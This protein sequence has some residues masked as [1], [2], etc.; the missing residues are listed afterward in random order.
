[1]LIYKEDASMLDRTRQFVHPTRVWI[2]QGP[3]LRKALLLLLLLNWVC[4][5]F[6]ACA[7]AAQGSSVGQTPTVASPATSPSSGT[8]PSSGA[9]A[10]N[11]G[12]II[13]DIQTARDVDV[14]KY[15][16]QLSKIFGTYQTVYVTFH[17]NSQGKDGSI[18]YKLYE[19]NTYVSGSILS[20]LSQSVPDHGYV[21]V[22]LNKPGTG[23]VELYWCTSRDCSDAQLQ[24]K[25]FFTVVAH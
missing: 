19:D 20:F 8:P 10:V 4:L 15:P 12:A 25:V 24:G 1:V 3:V 13:T 16:T 18:E 14:Q 22:Y 5:I 6:S 23:T 17:L 11:Q 9:G 7:N 2:E 21:V